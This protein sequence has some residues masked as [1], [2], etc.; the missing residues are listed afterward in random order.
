MFGF[1]PVKKQLDNIEVWLE[2]IA[3]GQVPA[4]QAVADTFERKLD[5]ASEHGRKM[6]RDTLVRMVRESVIE[7]QV[8]GGQ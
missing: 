6:S 8:K 2:L 5:E 4:P 7:N 3:E 1:K